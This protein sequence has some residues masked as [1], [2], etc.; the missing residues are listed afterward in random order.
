MI[1]ICKHALRPRFQNPRNSLVAQL[2]NNL[3]DTRFHPWTGKIPWRRKWKPTPVFLHG[4]SHRQGSL[5][6]YSP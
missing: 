1:G 6:G 2:V 3:Q 5:A 4:E